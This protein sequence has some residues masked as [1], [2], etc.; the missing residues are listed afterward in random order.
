M[1][2]SRSALAGIG[3]LILF[4]ALLIAAPLAI[5]GG[6]IDWPASLDFAASKALPLIV[7][8]VDAVRL[9]YGLYLGYSLLF[10]F[11]GTAIAWLAVRL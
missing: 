10:A 8:Q 1:S 11:G 2:A 6:A 7:E 5:L 3:A 9:G 4:E